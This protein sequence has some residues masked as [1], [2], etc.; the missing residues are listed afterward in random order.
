[1]SEREPTSELDSQYSSPDATPTSWTKARRLLRDA[2]VYWTS[3]VRPD[4]RPHVTPV[5][6]V[7][8][9]GAFYFPSGPGERKAKNLAENAQCV[10]TTGT[11]D[12]NNGFDVVVEGQASP[13]I[14]EATLTKLATAFA[15]KYDN[16]FGFE[17]RDGALVHGDGTPTGIYEVVP[18]KTF[19]YGRGE[20]Y[21]ATRF[22][23]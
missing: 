22:R 15:D 20:L 10:I 11:N 1:V 5:A 16:F 14:D 6:G 18:V 3:T 7:W 12:F 13:V 17:V 21:T 2:G 19:A 4:G 8:S 9:D 23:F